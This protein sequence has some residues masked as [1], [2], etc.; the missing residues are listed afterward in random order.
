M[1]P[2]MATD[3]V[4][5]DLVDYARRFAASRSGSATADPDWMAGFAAQL[6]LGCRQDLLRLIKSVSK[7]TTRRVDGVTALNF[8][9]SAIEDGDIEAWGMPDCAC[10]QPSCVYCGSGLAIKP[11]EATCPTK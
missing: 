2:K 6:R 4:K 5:H 10:Q 3:K 8:L 1:T 11:A 9:Y 7:D